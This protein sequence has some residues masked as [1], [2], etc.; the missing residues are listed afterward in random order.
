MAAWL[1]AELKLVKSWWW[2][3]NFDRLLLVIISSDAAVSHKINQ[4]IDQ[5]NK[6]KQK[7]FPD[8]LVFYSEKDGLQ[9]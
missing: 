5:K 9:Y 3:V 7:N 1:V 8:Y 4:W 6:T 2:S